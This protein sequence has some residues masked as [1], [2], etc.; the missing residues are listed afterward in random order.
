MTGA[1]EALWTL[2]YVEAHLGRDAWKLLGVKPNRQ[3]AVEI[4]VMM[5]DRQN[6]TAIRSMLPESVR[7][8]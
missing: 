6:L 7:F 2:R 5:T 1:Q 3:G 8:S 4:Q